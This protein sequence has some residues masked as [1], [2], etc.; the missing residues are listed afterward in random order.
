M[1]T[2]IIA[3]DHEIVR[4]GVRQMLL[5]IPNVSIVAEASDGLAAI[6]LVK[7]HQPDVLILDAAMP[8]ARGIEV[9]SDTRR[10]SPETRIA[11]VTGFTSVSILA[12][13]LDAGVDGIALK[14]SSSHELT[15][16]ITTLL[17]GGKY[18]TADAQKLLEENGTQRSLTA[19]ER[20][21]LTLIAAGLT[22]KAIA[23]RLSI[24]EKTAEKHRTS[25]MAKLNVRSMAGFAGSCGGKGLDC[26]ASRRTPY[27]Y[28][29]F[30][31]GIV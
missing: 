18:V 30:T 8:K 3:D 26:L 31:L 20:E 10:W 19:R 12:D 13:W 23:E 6:A 5:T 1:H 27:E 15:T 2:A 4:Q 11:L 14:S 29:C 22:N 17:H 25:L 7:K 16:C 9:L 21:V 24:S 28:Q